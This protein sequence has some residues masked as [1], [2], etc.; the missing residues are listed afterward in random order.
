M[1]AHFGQAQLVFVDRRVGVVTRAAH[2]RCADQLASGGVAPGMVGA[3]NGAFDFLGL[4]DKNHVT[5]PARVLEHPHGVVAVTHQKQGNPEKFNRFR[6]A[7][8][9]HIGGHGKPCPR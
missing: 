5:M 8:L 7:D 3:A 4:G 2:M 9:G 6:V 1:A